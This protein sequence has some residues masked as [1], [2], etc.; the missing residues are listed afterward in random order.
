MFSAG[1]DRVPAPAAEQQT[2]G[3]YKHHQHHQHHHQADAM[4]T[5]E[6]TAGEM[7]VEEAPDLA[8]AAEY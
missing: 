5:G 1:H 4:D 6:G 8:G 7:D 2:D 3:A